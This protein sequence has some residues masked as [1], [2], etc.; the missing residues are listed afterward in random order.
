MSS[1][2]CHLF[3]ALHMDYSALEL[4]YD[5]IIMIGDTQTMRLFRGRGHTEEQAFQD[6]LSLYR[7]EFPA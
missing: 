4:P 1:L 5:H 2:P 3:I 7:S 6:A